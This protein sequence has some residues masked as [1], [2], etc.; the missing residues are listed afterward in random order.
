MSSCWFWQ[1]VIHHFD[2]N[3]CVQVACIIKPSTIIFFRCVL[4]EQKRASRHKL[5]IFSSAFYK[6][7]SPMSS[8]QICYLKLLNIFTQSNQSL[9]STTREQMLILK[10]WLQ[11]QSLLMEIALI[12]SWYNALNICQFGDLNAGIGK[13]Y[14]FSDRDT[15]TMHGY[16]LFFMYRFSTAN[17]P[18]HMHMHAQGT[19]Q[20]VLS[21]ICLSFETK[22]TRSQLQGI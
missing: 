5:P 15:C 17:Y 4:T 22:I 13:I 2:V 21:V 16:T 1:H 11:L 3:S 12:H 19:K 7:A 6:Y 18:E 14:I 9:C 8:P 10:E 20:S